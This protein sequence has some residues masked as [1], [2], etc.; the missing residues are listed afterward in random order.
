MRTSH[1]FLLR[2]L[3]SLSIILET[4]SLTFQM[5]VL[6]VSPW[7]GLLTVAMLIAEVL[8]YFISQKRFALTFRALRNFG[9]LLNTAIFAAG[10]SACAAFDVICSKCVTLSISKPL[11]PCEESCSH[12]SFI[13][14]Y[15]WAIM[16]HTTITLSEFSTLFIIRRLLNS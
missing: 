13:K 7:L 3:L 6:K 2:G 10:F 1:L 11:H 9:H 12:A 15:F 4:S 5:M 16:L 8:L 14:P